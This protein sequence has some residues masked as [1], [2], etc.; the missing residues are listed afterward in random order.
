MNSFIMFIKI[1]PG[2]HYTALFRSDGVICSN[3]SL[4]LQ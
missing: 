1:K 2:F 4:I 3:T